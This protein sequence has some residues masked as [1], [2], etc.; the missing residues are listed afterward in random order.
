MDTRSGRLSTVVGSVLTIGLVVGACAS[1]PGRG[2]GS[3]PASIVL[4]LANGNHDHEALRPF[5][6]SAAAA[7]GGTVTIEFEDGVHRGEPAFESAI[8]DDVEEGTY[9][10]AWAAPRPWHAMGVTSF[11]ALMAPFLIDSYA[12]QQ[13]VLESDLEQEMLAGLD[14]TGL[15]GLG[16]LPG[17]LRRVATAEGGFRTAGDLRGKVVGI[18]DSEIAAKTFE[19]LGAST[20]NLPSGA[21]L[22]GEDAVEQQLGSVVGNRY[23]KEL[24][25]VTVDLA[26]WPRP[27]ILIANKA[28]FDILSDEQRTALRGV[29]KQLSSS[30]TA[31]VE[32]EDAS[33]VAV[34]CD[35][36]ADL[37]VA[38]D[39]AA[40][41]LRTTVEPVYDELEKDPATAAMVKR[42]T[43]MKAAIPTATPTTSCPKSSTSPAPQTA[44]GFPEGTYEARL[45]CDELEAY[46][47]AH[48]DLPVEDRFPCPVVMG[49]TLKDNTFVENYGERWKFSFFGDHIQLGNFT[50]RWEWDGKE[51]TFSEIDGGEE[52]D[53]QAWTTQPFVKLEDPV[54]PVVGFPDGTYRAQISA[55]EMKAYWEDHDVPL[56]LRVPCPCARDFT[57]SDGVWTGDDGSLWE[58]SFFGDK[59][60]LVDREGSFTLRWK[61]DPWLEEVTFLD[62]DAGGGAEETD[63]TTFFT[64]KPF[65][66]QQ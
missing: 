49:F 35:D 2:V 51:V 6:D 50:L 63:L 48:P 46:W 44:G 62:V 15:V 14:G 32:A 61:F 66:R 23:H 47:A 57:L 27:V 42:I 39:D 3:Q 52:G 17:P 41:A 12:L 21:V 25:H 28:R 54:T 38:G 43:E 56:D 58:P 16:I 65:D 34:L 5:A 40:A 37:V 1:P 18:H 55:D 4:S 36:G 11:D 7:T 22:S 59:L 33:A 30:T 64:V 26:L 8:I 10:L 9:D 31:A 29:A 20:K 19:A 53:E 13:A 24:P 45:S 60:T